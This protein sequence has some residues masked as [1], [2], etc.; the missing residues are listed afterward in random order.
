MINNAVQT[1]SKATENSF[2]AVRLLAA[3]QVAYI[4]ALAHL[5][6][7]PTWGYE[8]ISQFPGVPIFFA[9]SGYLVFDSALRL[10]TSTFF[11]HR[12]ARI[13]PALAVNIL[14]IELLLTLAGQSHFVWRDLLFFPI[15][16]G[17][18]S[19]GIAA[20]ISHSSGGGHAYPGFFQMYPSGV[21][22]TLTVE[23]SF[24]LLVP[25]FALPRSR[26]VQTILIILASLISFTYQKYL[27]ERI[28]SMDVWPISVT[29]LPYFWMFGI[30]MLFRLWPPPPWSIKPGTAVVLVAFVLI[31]K[32]QQMPW[33]EWKV[34][35]TIGASVQT[36]LLCL[37]ALLVGLSSFLKS[38]MLAQN[39]ASYGLYLYHMLIVVALINVSPEYRS[40]WLYL[41]VLVGGTLMGLLSWHLI[42]RPAMNFVRR[43]RQPPLGSEWKE[44]PRPTG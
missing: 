26:A 1:A 37:M 25:L 27:G 28:T 34:A 38:R 7:I 5:K 14:V 21:L 39:D 35:P 43:N 42:E 16:I 24:Y 3:L 2:N 23:L 33:F 6:L 40:Q 17:T 11:S 44:K 32:W 31:A 29:V 9:V 10:P 13:Y 12:R 19:D 8:W 15:Y 4:H 22:W 20:L 18:A 30:G 36:V 41:V